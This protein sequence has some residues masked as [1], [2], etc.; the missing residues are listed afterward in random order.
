IPMLRALRYIVER[1]E[2]R[3]KP[4]TLCGEMASKTV[5]ALALIALGYR[6]LSLVPSAD[7]SVNAMALELAVGNA[8]TLDKA[9]ISHTDVG[10]SIREKL[11]A[12]A[13]AEGIP[14]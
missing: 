10:A 3:A 12:F 1:G 7:A 9:L 5:S 6:R 2:A 13:E 8:E 4:F 14:L 11:V